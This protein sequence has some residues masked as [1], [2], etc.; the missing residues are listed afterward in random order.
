VGG[1]VI[2]VGDLGGAA[3]SSLLGPE[4]ELAQEGGFER[5]TALLVVFRW[6]AHRTGGG[7]S[8]LRHL[9]TIQTAGSDCTAWDR[10]AWKVL[11][12]NRVMVQG[13]IVEEAW[14]SHVTMLGGR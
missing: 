1:H 5:G 14:H 11:A 12:Q 6:E 3:V 10:F 7:G 8:E 13:L 9:E 2:L 4:V